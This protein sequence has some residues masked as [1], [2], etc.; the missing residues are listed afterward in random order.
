V[1]KLGDGVVLIAIPWL[2]TTIT[3][4]ALLVALMGVAV[5]LPWL[6]FSLPAGVWA[7]RLD[8]RLM[9]LTV[10]AVRTVLAG[11]LALLVW[12]D[13]LTLPMLFGLALA[14]GCC[15]VVFDN[16]SQVLLP[17]LVDRQRL[18]AANGRL[19]GA[20]MVLGEFVGR[21]LTGVLIGAS[22]ALPFLFDA[23]SALVSLLVLC[24]VRGS[25]RS[26]G[27]A[28]DAPAPA[29]RSMRAEIGEAMRWLWSHSL[30]RSL[31]IALAWSN[32]VHAGAFAVY[33]LYAQEILE[34]GP[35]GFTLLTSTGALGGF[36]GSLF[37]ARVSAR[38]GPGNSL[39]VTVVCGAVFTAVIALAPGWCCG[40]WSPSR[41]GRPSFRTSCWAGSTAVTGCSAGAVCR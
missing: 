40:T 31:A 26:G 21:P 18:E 2:T 11:G 20:Q 41:C 14:L 29:R 8:R 9:M 36:L 16:T 13:T 1:S 7:D 6:L 19:M 35:L 24:T 23:T 28:N 38:I 3:S 27:T 15:E 12:T 22:L 17:S 33:V 5:R 10:N 4:S 30:L 32:A 39:L 34:L 25:F 37:A